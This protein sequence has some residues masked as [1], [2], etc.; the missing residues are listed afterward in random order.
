MKSALL[1]IDMQNYFTPMTMSALPNILRLTTNF[2]THNCPIFCTQHGHPPSDLEEPITNQLVKKWGASGSL[3]I[4]TPEWEFQSSIQKLTSKSHNSSSNPITIIPKNTYDAFLGLTTSSPTSS[5]HS[6]GLEE[7]LQ[8]Q[9]VKRVVICG[10]M[11][12][13][14]CDT[15]GRSAFNRGFETWMVSDACGSASEA[16]HQR[17]LRA[18][19]FG[20]GDVITTDTVLARLEREGEGEE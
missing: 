4:N 6:S 14:C 12:D 1:I 9:N 20:Y 5:P 15:T 16:Q 10:V 7:K 11:T 2:T 19:G 3:H 8:Q 13:C 17:G 18:W